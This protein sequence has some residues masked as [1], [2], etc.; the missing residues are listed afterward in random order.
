MMNLIK[1]KKSSVFFA[2][3]DMLFFFSKICNAPVFLT[4]MGNVMIYHK[5][6]NLILFH[7]VDSIL[8]C[9]LKNW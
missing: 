3:I 2:N 8:L 1:E 6:S 9:T 5:V 4:R 7:K